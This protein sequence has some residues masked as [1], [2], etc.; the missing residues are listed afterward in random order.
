MT[1]LPPIIQ[2]LLAALVVTAA[3][4]D[5]RFRR[6]PNWLVGAGLLIGLGLNAFLYEWDGLIMAAKGF[7]IATL[8]YFPLYLVRGMGAGD[9]KLMMAVGSLVG[10]MNWLGICI[11]SVVVGGAAGLILVVFRGRLGQ[12]FSNMGYIITE[13]VH[14]RAPYLSRPELDT[15]SPKAL[16]LPHG[17]MIAIGALSFL[18]AMLMWAPR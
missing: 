5:I 13:L 16:T 11:L 14:F 18:G 4:Y 3:I 17:A 7:G 9:V 2:V 15:K 6:I 12:T 10:P 8:I 1:Y